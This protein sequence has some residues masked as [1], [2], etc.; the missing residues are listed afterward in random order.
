MQLTVFKDVGKVVR[1][2]SRVSVA[3]PMLYATQPAPH[4][5]RVPSGVF[6][7][8]RIIASLSPPQAALPAAQDALSVCLGLCD[9]P[10]CV[11]IQ[12][13]L[14]PGTQWRQHP[15]KRILQADQLIMHAAKT[16]S[17]TAYPVSKSLTTSSMSK[18]CDRLDGRRCCV[19]FFLAQ[20]RCVLFLL[21]F[22]QRQCYLAQ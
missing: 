12:I 2:S 18:W 13:P 7:S 3:S 8:S 5:P 22:A 15:A 17:H 19:M 1:G 14:V 11:C 20:R 10:H 21:P 16:R 9:S 6:P 4:R